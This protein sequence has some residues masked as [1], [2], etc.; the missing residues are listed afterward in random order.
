MNAMPW[1]CPACG[2]QI[3]HGESE[4]KPRPDDQYRCHYCRLELVLDPETDHLAATPLPA[5]R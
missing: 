3:R 5:D 1:Q 2:S 4:I